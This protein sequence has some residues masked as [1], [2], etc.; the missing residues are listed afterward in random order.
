MTSHFDRKRSRRAG[1][2]LLEIMVVLVILSAILTISMTTLTRPSDRLAMRQDIAVIRQEATQLRSE[3]IRNGME[4]TLSFKGC[5]GAQLVSVRFF[6]DGTASGDD[7]CLEHGEDVVRL[8]VE[9]VT[10]LLILVGD[11]FEG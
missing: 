1:F 3:A 5:D 11:Q 7:I 4:R 6:P 10:G 9:R 2:T 8:R